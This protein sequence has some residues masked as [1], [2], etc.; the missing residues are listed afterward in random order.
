MA[1]ARVSASGNNLTLYVTT[2]ARGNSPSHRFRSARMTVEAQYDDLRDVA[3]VD[4]GSGSATV[5][6]SVADAY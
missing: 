2:N 3:R 4:L 5:S 6:D 1:A